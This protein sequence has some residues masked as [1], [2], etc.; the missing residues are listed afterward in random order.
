MTKLPNLVA[1]EI[2][3]LT[4]HFEST[5]NVMAA[6]RVFSLAKKTGHSIPESVVTEIDRFADGISNIAEHAM[7]ADVNAYPLRFTPERLGAL[8]RGDGVKN[9]ADTLRRDWRDMKIG[10]EVNRL[11]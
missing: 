7:H 3:H 1:E 2:Q 11:V 5:G 4:A 10:W 9:P 6:W 8:W